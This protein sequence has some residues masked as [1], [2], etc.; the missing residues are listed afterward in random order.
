V[1]VWNVINYLNT[2]S[3]RVIVVVIVAAVAHVVL[4]V[5]DVFIAI[6][7]VVVVKTVAIMAVPEETT[8]MVILDVG[9]L[10]TRT[11][12]HQANEKVDTWLTSVHNY[13]NKIK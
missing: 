3:N 2:R 7:C 6:V 1:F 10:L 13:I 9:Q 5:F 4:V 11:L 8:A 12:A